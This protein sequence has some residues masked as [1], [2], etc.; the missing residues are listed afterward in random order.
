MVTSTSAFQASAARIAA[1]IASGWSGA[2][3]RS[4]AS[5]PA[6]SISPSTAKALEATIWSGPRCCPGKTSSSPVDSTA[7]RGFRATGS[8]GWSAAAASAT[9][10]GESLRPAHKIVSPSRKSTPTARTFLL[11]ATGTRAVTKLAVAGGVFL[12]QHAVGAFGQRRAGKDAHG[13]ARSADA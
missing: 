5:P 6:A 9:S 2:T 1:S 3:P 4:S 12:D 7:T 8:A 13:L 11:A 10:A